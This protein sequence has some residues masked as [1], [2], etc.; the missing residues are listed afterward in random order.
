[1]PQPVIIDAV[2]TP[3]ARREGAF[4]EIR[5]DALLARALTGLVE[6]TGI[7]PAKIE[8]VVNGCVTQAGEQGANVGR[9]AVLLAGFPVEV[10]AVTL[11]RMCGSSQ[12]SVHFAAQEVAAGDAAYTV[13]SGVEHMTRAPMFSD[14]GTLDK[15][16]PQLFQKYDLIHQGE[17]AERMAEKFK[18]TRADV[19]AFSM[20]SHKRAARAARDKCNKEILPTEGLDG[21]GKKVTLARDEGIREVLDPAKIASLATV[22]RPDGNG[23]VTAANSSQISDGAAAVLVADREVAQTDGLRPRARFLARVAVG[24]DPTLQLAGVIPATQKALKRAGLTIND[25]DW[26]EINEAFAT[27]VLGWAKELKPNMEKVNPWGGAIAHGHPLGATGAG[28][29]AKMLAGLE[30]TGGRL[31]LQTMC[32]GHGM[33]TATIIERL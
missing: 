18:I 25:I 29:L 33:A 14:I 31:G 20:E 3:F 6:R 24:D 11:N 16:N 23:V 27:V 7:P 15:M 9:L 21:E 4:R 13:G 1:M 2:R 17:S 30:A 22:F 19:D 10:P 26:I 32:I 12:Q 5:P 8:D 28:L